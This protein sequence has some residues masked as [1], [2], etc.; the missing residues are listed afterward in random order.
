[1]CTAIT[2]HTYDHYFGRNLDL[3]LS[4]GEK[5]VIT[6]R[7]YPLHFREV[8]TIKKHLAIYGMAIVIDNYPLYFDAANESGL[9][10]AGL[11]FDG[12]AYYNYELK[13]GY[14]NIS[15]FEF[16][17]WVLSQCEDVDDV[18]ALLKRLNLV[19]IDFSDSL[20]LSPLHWIVA[21]QNQSITIESTKE[22]LKVYDNPVGVLTNNPSFDYHMLNLNNYL[23]LSVKNPNN[24]F[25]RFLSLKAYS[26]G[27]G[28]IG[29]P[30]DLSSTSRFIRASFNKMNTVSED[31]EEAS[32]NNCF[33]IMT[34]VEQIN[35]LNDIGEHQ[36]ERTIYTACYNV[37]KGIFYYKTYDSS[38]INA[39]YL[40]HTNVNSDNLITYELNHEFKVNVQ[41]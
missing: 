27:M 26:R 24:E 1:M 36:Y 5:V 7:N 33:K 23:H 15:P 2:F 39:I 30:G 10:M 8:D 25:S 35:G 14:D 12:N 29:L 20:P 3:E 11:N 31:T 22:G 4:Y 6:P 40:H 13:D 41:N 34:S 37:D 18:H 16:I 17:P 21:D 38:M 19:N 28:A 32:V 9:S